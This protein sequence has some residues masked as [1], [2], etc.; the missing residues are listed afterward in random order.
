MKIFG[1]TGGI[2]SGKSTVAELFREHGISVLD[3]DR[4][5]HQLIEPLNA[6]PSPLAQQ[7]AAAF[8]DILDQEGRINRQALGDRIFRDPDARQ[9]LNAL[10]HPAVANAFNAAID[11]LR[12]N[13]KTLAL[14]D[15][16]LLYE[17]GKE[18]QFAGVIVVWVPEA[19]QRER[20]K[21]RDHLT[22]EQI[23]NRLQ[24]QLSL[25]I[26]RERADFVIDNS[27]ERSETR[28]QVASLIERLS[29]R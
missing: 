13:G 28:S 11:D 24:S 20:L 2:A 4:L 15:V 21:E 22:E 25:E 1:L 12:K 26:K 18:N 19:L 17:V 5:Y 7:L 6:Q 23:S 29:E 14:Y 3:A 8:G 16:P 27:G 9:K 10:T